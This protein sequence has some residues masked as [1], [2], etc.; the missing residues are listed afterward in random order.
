MFNLF[1]PPCFAAIGAMNAELGS[2]K[3]LFAGVGL[4]FGIGYSVGFL[5]NFFGSLVTWSFGEAWTYILGWALVLA[6][7]ATLVTLIVR[8]RKQDAKRKLAKAA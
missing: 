3:W 8:R 4:Q 5:V 7:A 1:S 6:F 2:K